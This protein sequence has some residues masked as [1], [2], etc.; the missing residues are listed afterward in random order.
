MLT[1]QYDTMYRQYLQGATTTRPLAPSSDSLFVNYGQE[2]NKIKSISDEVIYHPVKYKVLFG[3]E[4]TDDLKAMFKIVKNPDRVVNENELK[5]NVIAAINQYFA[6]ENWEFGDTFFF[7]E[8][9][10]YVMTQ[11]SP[12]LAA[13]VIVPTQ[14]TLSFGSMFEVKSEA[15]EVFISSATVA[16][17]EVVSSLTATNLKASGALYADA[18]AVQ[19][20]ASASSSII[21]SSSSSSGGLSY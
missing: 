16:N 13:I 7:T 12:D 3:T 21:S 1:K 17:I 18:T 2:I 4:A 19:G 10:A 14:E 9:S 15:D 11:V 5:A 8:L 6:I 20:V